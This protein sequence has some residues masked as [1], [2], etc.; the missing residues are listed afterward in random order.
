MSTAA[1]PIL[2]R[3]LQDQAIFGQA[4]DKRVLEDRVQPGFSV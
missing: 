3:R 1:S 2:N 4:I